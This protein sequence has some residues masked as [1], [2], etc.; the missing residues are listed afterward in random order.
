[1]NML[2]LIAMLCLALAVGFAHAQEAA[3]GL[4]AELEQQVRRIALDGTHAGA[5]GV[6]RVEVSVGQLDSRLRLAPCARIE[7]YLPAGTRLWGRTRIGL[8]CTE[9]ASKW[10]VYLPVTVKVYGRAWV[11]TSTAPAGGVLAA[12]DLIQAEVDLAEENSAVITDA[13]LAVGRTLLQPMK[14]GQTLR[15]AHLKP[16]QWFAAG[17]MVKVRAQGQGFN[18]ESEA[19]AMTNGIEGQTARVRTEGGRILT[20]QPV[21]ERQLALSM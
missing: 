18:V 16:R 17:E 3:S 8:R 5:P 1:M 21:G 4:P 9:G 14:A 15:I 6:P 20:G 7:P 13:A 2:R 10:N 12:A 19:E 11:T